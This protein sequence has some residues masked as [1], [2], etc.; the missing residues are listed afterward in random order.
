MSHLTKKIALTSLI[1]Y[2]LTN[3]ALAADQYVKDITGGAFNVDGSLDGSLFDM[4]APILVQVISFML[5]IAGFIAIGF[6]IFSGYLLITAQGNEQQIEQGKKSLIN[7]I[8]GL[9]IALSA[10]III[11]SVQRWIGL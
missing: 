9:I 5:A 10:Y 1:P 3:H 4:L 2:L 7:S 11:S 6:I 8:L